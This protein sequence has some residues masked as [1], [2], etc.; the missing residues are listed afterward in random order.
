VTPDE[1]VR[2]RGLQ[3]ALERRPGE[4]EL[5][6]SLDVGLQVRFCEN[7]GGRKEELD[8]DVFDGRRAENESLEVPGQ[9]IETGVGKTVV[10]CGC[11]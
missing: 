2:P 4:Q 11:P 10:V 7:D 8:E 1:P 6:E 5:R 3:G 9:V